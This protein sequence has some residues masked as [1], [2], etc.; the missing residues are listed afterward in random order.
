MSGRRQ[1]MRVVADGHQP[2]GANRAPMSGSSPDAVVLKNFRDEKRVVRAQAAGEI[3][4]VTRCAMAR[5]HLLRMG[6][7]F[8]RRPGSA[9]PVLRRG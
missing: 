4:P 6:T 3:Q 7:G 5:A 1:A 2:G 8:A 9:S